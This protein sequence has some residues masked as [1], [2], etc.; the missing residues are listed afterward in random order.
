M[1]RA[2]ITG[3][4]GQDGSYLA[5][6][7]LEKGYAVHGVVRRV[8][9]EDPAHRLARI[10]HLDGRVHLHAGSIESDATLYPILAEVQPDE[11]YHLAARSFVAHD[12][13]PSLFLTNITG[14]HN[15]LAAVRAVAPRARVYFAASSEIFGDADT[16]PQSETTTPRPRS[17]YGISKLAGMHLARRYRD[18]YGLFVAC[19]ILYNHE[20][21][22]RGHEFVTR[23]VTSHAARIKLGLA[24][25]LA[26]G[27][28]EA[29]RDWGH[30]RDYVR[31][32]WLM[33]QA[34]EPDDFVIATGQTQ[35]VADLAAAAFSELGLDWREHVVTDPRLVRPPERS[36]LAGDARKAAARLGWAPT[37]S[38]AELVREMVEAD[39]AA[40]AQP[41]VQLV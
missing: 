8:A 22:R 30:A 11:C 28:L 36:T 26:L 33:L 23:K 18:V 7:L 38:F 29:R 17:T 27:D 24:R 21:P 12:D 20:S 25:T 32:M 2:L 9:L 41:M 40:L 1:R 13:E 4:A 39:L 5:E 31:A 34:A 37:V 14:T 15:L 3:I 16:S 10:A 19:G 35:T 6:L